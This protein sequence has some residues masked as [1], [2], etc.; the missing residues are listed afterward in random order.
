MAAV[1]GTLMVPGPDEEMLVT[2]CDIVVCH[3]SPVGDGRAKVVVVPAT[4]VQYGNSDAVVT[5]E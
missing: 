2:R 5:V 1:G 4:P 3:A